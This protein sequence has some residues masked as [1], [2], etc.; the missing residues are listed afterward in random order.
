MS[1]MIISLDL[2]KAKT[3]PCRQINHG[4][5]ISRHRDSKTKKARHGDLGLKHYNIEKWKQLTVEHRS[6]EHGM[7]EH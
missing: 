3:R 5:E 4:I 2:V 6:V 7:L 1:T